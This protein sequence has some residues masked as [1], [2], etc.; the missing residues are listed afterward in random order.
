MLTVTGLRSLLGACIVLVSWVAVH[1]QDADVGRREF[2]MKCATCHGFDAKGGGPTAVKLK[3]KAP[4][5]TTLAK[6]N[7]G[8]F[9]Q[10][11]IY[12]AIDGRAGTKSHRESEMPI[13]GCRHISPAV[14]KLARKSAERRR[15]RRSSKKRLTTRQRQ[16]KLQ[17]RPAAILD[18]ACDPEPVIRERILAAID[19]LRQIQK[20]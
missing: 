17:N 4:D 11:A 10:R 1:A 8:I 5:L 19:Y 7:K 13:W 6:Q 18:L 16:Q 2:L 15:A 14:N 3:I 12:D 20:Q 9:P